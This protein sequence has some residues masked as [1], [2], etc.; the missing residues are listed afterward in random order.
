MNTE[1]NYFDKLSNNKIVPTRK[2]KII[3]SIL[4]IAGL[5]IFGW[6][7]F[8]LADNQ[9]STDYETIVAEVETYKKE[10]SEIMAY[11]S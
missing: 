1:I 7:K 10:K 2:E 3:L 5:A 9:F 8:V 11:L 4:I 6:F